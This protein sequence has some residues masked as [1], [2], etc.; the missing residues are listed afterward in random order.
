MNS[1]SFI[2]E[3]TEQVVSYSELNPTTKLTISGFIAH[4]KD[5]YAEVAEV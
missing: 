4:L 2:E 5:S 3:I 1:D